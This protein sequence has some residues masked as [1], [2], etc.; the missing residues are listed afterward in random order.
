M[1][2]VWEFLEMNMVYDDMVINF[3]EWNVTIFAL[4]VK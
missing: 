2:H 1:L 3:Y 4:E